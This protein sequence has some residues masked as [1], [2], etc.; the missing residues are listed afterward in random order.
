VSSEGDDPAPPQRLGWSHLA[1]SFPAAVRHV[2]RST[3]VP[4]CGSDRLCACVCHM[5]QRADEQAAIHLFSDA[6]SVSMAAIREHITACPQCAGANA[7]QV[8]FI[9]TSWTRVASTAPTCTAAASH[10]QHVGLTRR[11]RAQKG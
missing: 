6:A 3:R 9:V 2:K 11:S 5:S 8:W 1:S 10:Q 4:A 7:N